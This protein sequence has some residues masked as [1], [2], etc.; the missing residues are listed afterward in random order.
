VSEESLA[1][2]SVSSVYPEVVGVM[3]TSTLSVPILIHPITRS[4]SC[5]L[6]PERLTLYAEPA[7]LDAVALP[8]C[9]IS[10]NGLPLGEVD[11]EDEEEIVE[12]GVLEGR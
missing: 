7:P 9:V 10:V 12:E 6:K 11:G 5:R 3:F 1:N 2:K 8:T 4:P